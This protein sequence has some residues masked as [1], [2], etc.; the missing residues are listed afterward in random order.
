VCHFILNN[1]VLHYSVHA[2][3]C[4]GNGGMGPTADGAGDN[5]S[6]ID[7]FPIAPEEKRTGDN[8]SLAT[9]DGEDGARTHKP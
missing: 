1:V 3:V 9:A 8:N 7:H 5:R 6:N 2:G 4:D